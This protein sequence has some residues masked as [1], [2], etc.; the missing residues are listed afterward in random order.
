M[1]GGF[2][3]GDHLEL[4]EM[5][6]AFLMEGHIECLDGVVI[7]VRKII[8]IIVPDPNDPVVRRADY[9]YHVRLPGR[10]LFR[11][12]CPHDDHRPFHHVHRY[13]IASGEQAVERLL[14]EDTPTLGEVIEE[15]EGWYYENYRILVELG[16]VPG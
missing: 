14:E 2:V 16:I 3:V 10:N 7:E 15:A 13:D 5:D 11:Y 6:H 8:Q 1:D 4:V 9:R 12:D